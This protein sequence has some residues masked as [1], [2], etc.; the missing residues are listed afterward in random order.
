[1]AESHDSKTAAAI[2]ACEASRQQL[3]IMKSS[4]PRDIPGELLQLYQWYVSRLGNGGSPAAP[5]AGTPAS[6]ASK[7][8]TAPRSW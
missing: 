7:P 4:G 3:T 6:N 8:G 1:M 2:L 5:A